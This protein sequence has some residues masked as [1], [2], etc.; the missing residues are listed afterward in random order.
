MSRD[1]LKPGEVL[2]RGHSL[3]SNNGQFRLRMQGDGNLVLY[4]AHSNK[5]LRSFKT[6]RYNATHAHMQGDGNFVISRKKTWVCQTGTAGKKGAHLILQNDGNLVLYTKNQK[7]ALY[8][9]GTVCSRGI[10]YQMSEC[11]YGWRVAY[12]RTI[13]HVDV[14]IRLNWESS[15]S[16]K[17]RRELKK[18][19]TKG[20][21]E[22][23]SNKYNC[24][25]ANMTLGVHWITGSSTN[26]IHD[27]KVHNKLK[28]ESSATDFDIGDTGAVAAHEVGHMLGLK[29]EYVSKNGKCPNRKPVKTGTVMDKTTGPAVR[30]HIKLICK[31]SGSKF[32]SNPRGA[33]HYRA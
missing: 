27:V 18:R 6:K 13:N 21:I 33:L 16:K 22:K 28:H 32:S 9:T 10:D 24:R 12:I 30:R 3:W 7:K 1:R 17:K 4:I 20:I 8:S 26:Y 2:K 19:W 31:R 23:W 15:I 11:G 25:G 29:D 14:Q 5:K